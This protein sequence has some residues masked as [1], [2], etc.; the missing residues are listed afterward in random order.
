MNL[1]REVVKMG[2]AA[3]GSVAGGRA[4][5][6]PALRAGVGRGSGFHLGLVTYNVAKDWNLD[7]LLRLREGGRLVGIV[8]HVL[9]LKERID[10]RLA[11]K[12]GPEGS[13]AT[14]VLP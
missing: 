11:V 8:S 5:A 3:A 1:C 14:L 13:E 4:W 2:L 7:T 6:G 10:V 9:E 12:G